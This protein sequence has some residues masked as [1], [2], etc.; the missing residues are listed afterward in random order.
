MAINI[1][2]NDVSGKLH[3]SLGL[4]RGKF[5][6]TNCFVNMH[7]G[8]SMGGTKRE[9]FLIARQ[10]STEKFRKGGIMQALYVTPGWACCF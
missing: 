9:L 5:F 6:K 1:I 7:R 4:G 2:F 10:N 8:G 3:T